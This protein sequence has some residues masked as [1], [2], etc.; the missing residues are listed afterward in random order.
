[1]RRTAQKVRTTVMDIRNASFGQ[2]ALVAAQAEPEWPVAVLTRN[3]FI[4]V[5][6]HGTGQRLTDL[7]V[8]RRRTTTSGATGPLRAW[9]SVLVPL[10][11]GRAGTLLP[12]ASVLKLAAGLRP[13]RGQ[14]LLDL[15]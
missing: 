13:G 5:H 3:T 10:R 2:A 15:V 6:R 12:A 8:P 7:G 4:S 14:D 9:V 1:M 11:S